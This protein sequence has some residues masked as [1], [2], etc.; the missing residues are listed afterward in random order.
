[1][2]CVLW[3][4]AF[5][6]KCPEVC[7]LSADNIS[8]RIFSKHC[9]KVFWCSNT[10]CT[11]QLLKF[12]LVCSE[13]GI[14]LPHTSSRTAVLLGELKKHCKCW[15]VCQKNTLTGLSMSKPAALSD[16]TDGNNNKGMFP[17][18]WPASLLMHHSLQLPHHVCSEFVFQ[19]FHQEFFESPSSSVH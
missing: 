16:L 7:S 6:K 1:M 3:W 17:L 2:S 18:I 13:A 11:V 12:H 9:F 14:I 5:Q 10:V 15:H 19:L 4:L 8:I